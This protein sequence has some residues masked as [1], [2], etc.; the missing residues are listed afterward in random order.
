MPVPAE[1]GGLKLNANGKRIGFQGEGSTVRGCVSHNLAQA[2]SDVGRRLLW[3][4]FPRAHGATTHRDAACEGQRRPTCRCCRNA[5]AAAASGCCQRLQLQ[6]QAPARPCPAGPG[7]ALGWKHCSVEVGCRSWPQHQRAHAGSCLLQGGCRGLYCCWSAQRQ[8]RGQVAVWRL[9]DWLPRSLHFPP[10][11]GR[12]PA[13]RRT[14]AAECAATT[15]PPAALAGGPMQERAVLRAA[16][17][18]LP[19]PRPRRQQLRCAGRHA[20]AD[21][22]GARSGAT[23]PAHGEGNSGHEVKTLTTPP[24]APSVQTSVPS[25][26]V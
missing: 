12:E 8:P 16:G 24:F 2:S 17:Q 4:R 11:P 26:K 19:P 10:V 25:R 18:P 3:V 1:T 22:P 14:S 13:A 21:V 20:G 7:P 9:R 5:P 6:G 15:E 23:W